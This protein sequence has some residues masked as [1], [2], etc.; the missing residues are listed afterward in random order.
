MTRVRRDSMAGRVYLDLQNVARRTGRPT[1]ELLHT[2]ALEGLLARL[3]IS[4][5]ASRLVLKGG[6]LLAA[7]QARRPTRDV[8]LSSRDLFGDVD[9]VL[10]AVRAIATHDLDDGLAFHPATATA[11]T[12]REEDKY[13]GVRV[14]LPCTLAS[15]R[16][17]FHVDVNVGD[18]IWPGPAPV[19]VPRVL[20]G[21][22]EV[23]GYPLAM[24]YAEKIV[25]AVDRG[26]A[27]TR[28]RDFADVYLL[29]RAR[30]QDG[31]ELVAAIEGVARH[32]SV[33][34]HPLRVVLRGFPERAQARWS[35]WCTKQLLDDRLPSNFA[36]V[37]DPVTAFAEPALDGSAA[38]KAWSARVQRWA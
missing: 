8:D 17:R 32:R 2:Y 30:D 29:S 5:Y 34:L 28:W 15:A 37:L 22:I 3:A 14:T 12:I 9:E 10:A 23:S 7:F 20:G 13:A 36:E 35:A 18:P 38:G 4:P 19:A 21:S 16:I 11:V 6:V 26:L 31:T 33:V 25:T 1:A 27:N 24:V